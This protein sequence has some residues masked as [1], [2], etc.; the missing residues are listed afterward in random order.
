MKRQ[1]VATGGGGAAASAKASVEL[2]VA[3]E[4]EAPTMRLQ[5]RA[6]RA[7]KV[8]RAARALAEVLAAP[9]GP[10]ELVA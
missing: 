10:E 5:G 9:A 1:V 8:G 4:P 7:A 2:V 3:E 6:D